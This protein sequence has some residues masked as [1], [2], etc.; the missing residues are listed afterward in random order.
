MLW[1]N[2]KRNR[3]QA[4]AE[5]MGAFALAFVINV[6][7]LS[8]STPNIISNYTIFAT[9]LLVAS[10]TYAFSPYFT[11][12]LN[13]LVTILSLLNSSFQEPITLEKIFSTLFF[14]L[15]QYVGACA[16]GLSSSLLILE[17]GVK[18]SIIKVPV[19]PF[20]HVEENMI[21]AS[22]VAMMATYFFILMMLYTLQQSAIH[23][24]HHR[25]NAIMLGLASMCALWICS[26]FSGGFMNPAIEGALALSN[27]VLGHYPEKASWTHFVVYYAAASFG[28]MM[29]MLSTQFLARYETSPNDKLNSPFTNP[30]E[31]HSDTV[32]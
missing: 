13:P 11:V 2:Y 28:G 1:E 24:N 25:G 3:K 19:L 16:G 4:C 9:G 30:L 7:A 10:L 23:T 29:A 31:S 14:V 15:A 22:I 26:P 18:Q 21:Y 5:G 32:N 6:S 12:Y 20:R 17:S 8:S 27:K